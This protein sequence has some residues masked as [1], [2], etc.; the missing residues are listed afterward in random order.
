MEGKIS[1]KYRDALLY[2]LEVYV[3][4]SL[5]ITLENMAVSIAPDST[6]QASTRQSGRSS[7]GGNSRNE[8]ASYSAAI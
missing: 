5:S 6:S 4:Q 7:G 8:P 2:K 3:T 1:D